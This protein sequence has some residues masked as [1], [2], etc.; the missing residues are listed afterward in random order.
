MR[1]RG[2]ERG[3]NRRTAFAWACLLAVPLVSTAQT[4]P[5]KPKLV[6]VLTVA[7]FVVFLTGQAVY[8]FDDPLSGRV[9]GSASYKP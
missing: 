9:H 4:S 6:L 5:P 7:S 1:P 8:K 3:V 2:G